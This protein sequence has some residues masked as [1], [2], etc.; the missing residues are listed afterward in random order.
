MNL[1]T[2]F[3]GAPNNNWADDGELTFDRVS[4][5]ESGLYSVQA[6]KK[7]KKSI[8]R[9]KKSKASLANRKWAYI[10]SKLSSGNPV[11]A[12]VSVMERDEE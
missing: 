8:K 10:C 4:F 2:L 6:R 1:R 9:N 11:I 7:E 3:Q 5:K 12:W